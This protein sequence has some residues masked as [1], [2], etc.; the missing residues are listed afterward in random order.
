MEPPPFVIQERGLV[1]RWIDVLDNVTL[2]GYDDAGRLVKTI[3]NA[4]DDDYDN[5]Y[6]VNGD[7]A[8]AGYTPVSAADQDLITEQSYDANGNL[9]RQVDPPGESSRRP[10]HWAT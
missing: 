3:Q 7:P 8:L 2:F 9:V 10:I 1:R 4:S 6:G 5:S